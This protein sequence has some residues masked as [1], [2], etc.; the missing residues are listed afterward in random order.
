MVKKWAEDIDRMMAEQRSAVPP[1]RG[2]EA[3]IEALLH[4]AGLGEY[5]ARM[6]KGYDQE[7]LLELVR[8]ALANVIDPPPRSTA[9]LEAE[10]VGLAIGFPGLGGMT[11][12]ARR[13][14]VGKAAISR[15]AVALQERFGLPPSC[16]MK[17]VES[18]ANYRQSN[19]R[20][21]RNN[22]G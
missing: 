17:S 20:K 16:Y 2:E 13:H 14:G 7:K 21:R 8:V 12:A 22:N 5:L 9:A 15:R 10:I 1:D 3:E 11:E 19:N 6:A 18:R 4:E